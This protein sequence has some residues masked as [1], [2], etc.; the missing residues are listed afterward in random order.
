MKK[1]KNGL[2]RSDAKLEEI[3]L[4]NM[5]PEE[6]KEFLREFYNKRKYNY[7]KTGFVR[8]RIKLIFLALFI[9]LAYVYSIPRSDETFD[10]FMLP[11]LISFIGIIV[12]IDHIVLMRYYYRKWLYVRKEIIE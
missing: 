2:K 4:E 3:R 12:L 5:N 6:E 9:I 7:M 11:F 1:I 8:N 10:V